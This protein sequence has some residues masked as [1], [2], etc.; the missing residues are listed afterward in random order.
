[1]T[2]QQ[3][4]GAAFRAL[5]QRDGLFVLPNPWDAGSAKMLAHLGFE[6]LATTSAG[7][8][9][10]L[11]RRDAEGTVS[12]DEALA[13]A[14]EIVE[15]TSLPVAADLE[16][17][18]GDTP[19][20]CAETIRLAAACGLVGGSIEDATGRP[21]TP[22]Y[23]LELAVE[24]VAAAVQAARALPFTFTLVARAEN[25]LHGRVDLDDTIR[26][27]V[28]FAEAGADVLYA[29]GLKT[30]EE[31]SAVVQAVAPRPVNVLVGSPAVQL[32][33]EELAELG[34]K[35]VSVGST[36]ARAA[37]GAFFSASEALAKGDL[38]PMHGAMP[39][40]RINGLFRG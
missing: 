16:N 25:F 4:R 36:L 24:R 29:P 39:F 34:V 1:M 7:L 27:L 31:I 30:R 5:H 38:K 17:G 15:A 33:L 9:F 26:R 10:A 28:A 11:G 18:Y 13:N 22:I 37:Y 21:D 20:D 32:S 6:A 35:R 12:R 40:D 2:T 19:D 14:R 8:A 23:P 3:Q